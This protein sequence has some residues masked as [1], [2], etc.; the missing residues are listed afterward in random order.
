[1]DGYSQP[2]DQGMVRL[3]VSRLVLGVRDRD[4]EPTTELILVDLWIGCFTSPIGQFT[5]SP[6]LFKPLR[7]PI[8]RIHGSWNSSS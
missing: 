6:L 4:T 2:L 3:P 8:R 1:M 7:R 5:G